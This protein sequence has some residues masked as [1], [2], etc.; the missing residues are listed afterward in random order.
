V[1]RREAY[2][3][4]FHKAGGG[5]RE[6]RGESGGGRREEGGDRGRLVMVKVW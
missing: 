2:K 5:R 4:K 6:E 1:K 3:H